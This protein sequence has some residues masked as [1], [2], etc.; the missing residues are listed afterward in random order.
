MRPIAAVLLVL[1]LALQAPLRA[2][3]PDAAPPP[4]AGGEIELQRAL[5]QPITLAL[6]K[7]E[8]SEAFK[9]IA[10]T[11]KIPLQVD[12]A[13]YDFLP[14]GATIS[15]S[16]D[17]RESK[18]RDSLE[19][20]LLP[21]GLQQTVSGKA[22]FIRPSNALAHIGHRADWEELKLLQDLH[23]SA[24]L[25]PK[26]AGAFNL[27]DALR[28]SLDGRKD[29]LVTIANDGVNP[30]AALEQVR[31]QLPIS[32]FR[33]LDLYCQLTNQIWF[34]ETGA[35]DGGPTGGTIHIMSQRAWIERQLD[36]PIQ[37]SRTNEALE[38]VVADLTRASGIRFVP[39]PGL[40]KAVPVVSVS[41]NNATV[42]Q[43]LETMAGATGVAFEVRD[44]SI[45]LKVALRPGD[46]TPASI[47]TSVTSPSPSKRMASR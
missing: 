14:Y 15:I 35:L 10:A 41:S 4:S 1:S 24:D 11:A 36:R 42:K 22:V 31:K 12:P 8:L 27:T 17:F 47:P 40:Y 3:A 29:L 28:E 39:E 7:V 20:I 23:K 46:N 26:T 33:A 37:M 30:A 16:T 38:L 9:Q 32:P 21:L 13:C 2:Q 44:D 5:D 43:T 25:R 18:L 19:E 6:Q 45:L 34:V